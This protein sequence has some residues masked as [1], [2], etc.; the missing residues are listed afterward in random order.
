MIY[1]EGRKAGI[2]KLIFL[3]LSCLPYFFSAPIRNGATQNRTV[4][5]ESI[6]D[7][8]PLH[9]GCQSSFHN[10]IVESLAAAASCEPSGENWSLSI[11]TELF[12]TLR[13]TSPV[14]AFNKAMWPF[15]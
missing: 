11:L 4:L 10:K 14:W 2:P 3:L 13:V 15:G 12:L 9:S 7:G 1:Q 6:R 5:T 8:R